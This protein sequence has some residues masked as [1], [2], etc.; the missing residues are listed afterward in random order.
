MERTAAKGAKSITFTEAPH[1]LGLPSFHGDHWDPFFAA[2]QTADM[3][4][5]LHFGSGG[6]PRHRT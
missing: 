1:R 2:A 4:L 6:A 5:C 3:P